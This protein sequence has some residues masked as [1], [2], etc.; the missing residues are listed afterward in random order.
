MEKLQEHFPDKVDIKF[1]ENP[2]GLDPK[3]GEW[4]YKDDETPPDIAWAHVVLVNN[5]S[6]FGGPYTLRCIGVA[7]RAKKFV[8]FDTDDLLTNLY[9]EHQLAGVYKEQKLED[10][11]KHM[12]NSCNLVTVTQTKFANRIKPYCRNILA[13]IKN[14]IDYNLPA[15]QMEKSKAPYVRVGWAGGIHHNPDVKVFSSVPHLVNQKVGRENIRWDFYGHPPPPQNP[16]EKKDWQYQAWNHYKAQLL[17]G[18]KGQQNFTVNYALPPKDYGI[19]Y[20]NMDIAIAPLQWNEFN[21]SKSDIKVAEAGRYKVPLIAS[22]VGCYDETIK[23]GETGYLIDPDA[24]KSEW[25]RL[26]TKVAKDRNHREEM[27]ERLHKITE[28]LFNVNKVCK[29]RLDIYEQ[30]FK[31]LGWDP[32]SQV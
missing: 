30:S 15:W 3:T 21:D 14:A 18:F 2:L 12:Y 29:H 16:A 1:N 23:N 19:F 13:V 7:A 20:A 6:N 8:H 28:E 31:A 5:I 32:R 22:N 26:L 24:P 4:Q 10:M 25:V 9:D 11:T 17:K 27:G